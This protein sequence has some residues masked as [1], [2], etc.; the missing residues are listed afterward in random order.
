M[1]I[2]TCAVGEEKIPGMAAKGPKVFLLKPQKHSEWENR[3]NIII[4]LRN[5]PQYRGISLESLLR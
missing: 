2:D 3:G 5:D 1:Y 4:Y